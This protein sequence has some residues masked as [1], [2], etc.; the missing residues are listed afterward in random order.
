MILKS[1]RI[2]GSVDYR[3]SIVPEIQTALWHQ[4]TFISV[5][6]VDSETAC[7]KSIWIYYA[8][9]DHLS[10]I[11]HKFLSSVMPTLER[12]RMLNILNIIRMTEPIVMRLGMHIMPPETISAA[13]LRNPSPQ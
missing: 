12:L 9:C 10:E 6:R 13:Y 5:W 1:V 11:N 7:I 4:L 8:I 2:T 3:G